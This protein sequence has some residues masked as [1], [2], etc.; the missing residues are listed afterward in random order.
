MEACLETKL[1]K[2]DVPFS[3]GYSIS[4][5]TILV[6]IAISGLGNPKLF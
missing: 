4:S 2:P 5:D 3:M 1:S 6:E